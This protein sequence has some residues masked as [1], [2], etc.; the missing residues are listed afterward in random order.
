MSTPTVISTKPSAR[1]SP[2]NGG[3]RASH[4]VPVPP[5]NTLERVS[6][7]FEQVLAALGTVTECD[8]LL[9]VVAREV[10]ALVGVERCTIALRAGGSGL[11]HGCVGHCG[12]ESLDAYVKRLP[13][14]MPADGM[15][16]EVLRTKRPVVIDNA[17][18]DP[19][20]IK[21]NV[22]FWNIRSI[23]AVPLVV[24][25]TVIGLMYLDNRARS[26]AFS[27]ADADLASI[28]GQL[29]AASV[30][31]MQ[32]RLE[33]RSMVD[34][35][36]RE[37]KALR[38]TM[39]VQER[40]TDF[41]AGGGSL[42]QLVEALANIVAKPCAVYDA[43]NIQL[44]VASAPGV[45][46]GM[47]PRLLDPP[48]ID[49]PAVREALAAGAAN[50]AFLVGPLPD[51]GVVRRHLV[52]PIVVNGDL[53]GRL[54]VMEH[55][56]RFS[57][58]D[59]LTARRGASLVALQMGTARWAVEDAWTAGASLV[60]ELVGGSADLVAVQR[61]ADRLGLPLDRAHVVVHIR[62]R[63]HDASRATDMRAVVAALLAVAPDV[64]VHAGS[65]DGGVAVLVEVPDGVVGRPILEWAKELIERAVS[66]L[67]ESSEMVAG[68]SAVTSDLHG[69]AEAYREARQ[70]VEC[71]RR[72]GTPSGPSV[73]ATAD[74]GAG[75]V[76]LA[77]CDAEVVRTFSEETFAELTRDES[78]ADLL[79]TLCAF[80]DNLA[81]IRRCALQLGVH[82]NTIRYRLGRIEELTGLPI[83]HDPDGQLR[84][85]LSLLV[86]MLQDRLP[87]SPPARHDRAACDRQ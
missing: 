54:V 38:R 61:R 32:T 71:I 53:W 58:R 24:Q 75:R 83:T 43:R 42:Q 8:E 10:S 72:F 14:G 4:G 74:L 15:T 2:R 85:R 50:R 3:A 18:T 33:L 1:R 64:T 82:E 40:L 67:D 66:D 39:A 84:A 45:S 80:F 46:D 68:I 49:A 22:R 81:S 25:N 55:R 28:F 20:M 16:A 19:R 69:Y 31:Q 13:A 63:S 17:R 59:M 86:L 9:R 35:A 70:V 73:L 65:L 21:S 77:T 56:T 37:L 7:A 30:S 62:S 79:A 41:V 44:A 12:E 6:A 47:H 78:K 87:A 29:A 23:M 51:A 11:F 76:F 27:K 26:H 57:G 36:E 52:A 48:A 34:A 60:A 5:E